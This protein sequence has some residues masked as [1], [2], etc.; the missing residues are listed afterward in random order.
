[1]VVHILSVWSFFGG[2]GVGHFQVTEWLGLGV[3]DRPVSWIIW[4][5]W[6]EGRL[7]L[8]TGSGLDNK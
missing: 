7:F 3:L 5:I 1:M 6:G 4:I 8:R 2:V